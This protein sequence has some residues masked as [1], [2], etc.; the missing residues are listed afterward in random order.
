MKALAKFLWFVFMLETAAAV[1]LV[2][3]GLPASIAGTV[4]PLKD[5]RAV[6]ALLA[7][8]AWAASLCEGQNRLI[9]GTA[10]TESFWSLLILFSVFKIWEWATRYLSLSAVP[11]WPKTAAFEALTVALS[12]PI[13]FAV[14][15]FTKK[16]ALAFW[17][18][19]IYLFGGINLSTHRF[20][21]ED[22]KSI[23][24]AKELPAGKTAEMNAV[25]LTYSGSRLH[26]AFSASGA[27]DYILIDKHAPPAPLTAGQLAGKLE[28]LQ[29]SA[30]YDR[31][32]EDGSRF[33]FKKKTA[34]ETTAGEFKGLRKES[35]E[36]GL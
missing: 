30:D 1:F 19:F 17:I 35:E 33:L 28:K 34:Q 16:T 21:A 13:Y 18:A 12:V 9:K 20:T 31:V 27:P 4:L 32:V 10:Q 3:S 36:P 29:E 22:V 15:N 8:T 26:H 25:L 11:D 23:R 2:W 7:A 24:W 5:F 14:R 6:A